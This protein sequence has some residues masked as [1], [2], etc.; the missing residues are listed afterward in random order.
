MH[1]SV[2]YLTGDKMDDYARARFKSNN[3]LTIIKLIT[4]DGGFNPEM[5]FVNFI[6]DSDYYKSLQQYVS[7]KI[8]PVFIVNSIEVV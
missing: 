1:C 6:H 7:N 8:Q 4:P 3:T 5:R 2:F